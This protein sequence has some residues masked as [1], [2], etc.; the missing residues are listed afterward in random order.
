MNNRTFVRTQAVLV[1]LLALLAM[2]LLS[3]PALADVSTSRLGGV[4]RYQTMSKI[5]DA[6]FSA[7]DWAVV[8]TAED[9]PDALAASALAG[10]KACPVILTSK[11]AL[12]AEASYELSRLGVKNAY[13]V[14]GISSLSARVEDTI[15]MM[16]ISVTRLWGSGRVETSLAVQKALSGKS[17]TIVIVSGDS[18]PDALSIGPWCWSSVSPIVLCRAGV[19][20]DAAIN[21]IKADRTI[22]DIVIVGGT[23]SVA[24]NVLLQL[25]PNYNYTR[26]GGTDRYD[27]S[28]RVAEWVTGNG[29][30]WTNPLLATG[31]NF[32]D[33]LAGSALGGLWGS[34]LLLVSN[35]SLAMTQKV[36]AHIGAISQFTILG[37]ESSLGS[38]AVS[39]MISGNVSGGGTS[40]A[41]LP[42]TLR[43]VYDLRGFKSEGGDGDIGG[44]YIPKNIAEYRTTY[45]DTGILK[46]DASFTSGKPGQATG[47]IP[48]TNLS[49]VFYGDGAQGEAAADA[50]AI[51]GPLHALVEGITTDMTVTLPDLADRLQAAN[52]AF[53]IRK[54]LNADRQSKYGS[55]IRGNNLCLS[56]SVIVSDG[57]PYGRELAFVDSTGPFKGYSIVRYSTIADIYL[58]Q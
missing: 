6:G 17:D 40:S 51:E 44:I 29:L 54:T 41:N 56:E 43:L 24:D 22:T 32:P 2:C 3:R 16:G 12:S 42:D 21:Q 28:A 38:S 36:Q 10:S 48:G 11:N 13:I 35:S 45:G 58:Q 30:D 39:N 52:G 57:F 19:L 53:D 47:T 25:G 8:A 49:V 55:M 14:G 46:I 50:Y 7:S 23:A 31:T 4:N 27:T 18:F 33:A 20:S 26:L 1:G 34:P 37:G 9:F 5:V 15:K